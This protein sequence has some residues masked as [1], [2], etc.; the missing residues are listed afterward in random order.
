MDG[1]DT[2]SLKKMHGKRKAL[3]GSQIVNVWV[4]LAAGFSLLCLSCAHLSGQKESADLSSWPAGASPQKIGRRVAE[5]FL[6][7]P[8]GG[9]NR[10]SPPESIPYPEVCTW[11]GALTFARLVA[12]TQLQGKLIERFT[13][14]LSDKKNLIPVPDHVDNTV[15]AAVPLELYIQ[16]GMRQY[17]QIGI[18]MADSQWGAP[19]GP[20]AAEDSREY[21]RQGYSWQTRMWIDDMYMITA[22]QA[23]A[24]RATGSRL[25]IDRAAREMAMYLDSLQQPN[26]LFYHA[27]DV[28]FFWG[29]GNGWMA[30]GMS[31]LLRSLPENDPY[32]SRILRGYRTMMASLLTY[33]DKS[34]LWHQIIDHPE[35]WEETSCTGMFTFAMITGVKNGWLDAELYGLAARKGWLGLIKHIDAN[36]DIHGVCEGTAKKNDLQYYL[37]RKRNLGDLHGQAPLLWC[38]SALLR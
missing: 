10:T 2:K 29:R 33:Q 31:E 11:Y 34:G 1:R 26:G 28:P 32:R 19:F 8:Y 6:Q 24:Y 12:D 36:A 22:A 30:A 16:T 4:A 38:A 23:Q 3:S 9:F 27:P 13:P 35:S 7:T 37:A 14:L 15:F 25:Y 18:S 21:F 17:F 5:R 20:N